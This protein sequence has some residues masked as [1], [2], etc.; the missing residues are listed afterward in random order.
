MTH[1]QFDQTGLNPCLAHVHIMVI[2][3]TVS[4]NIINVYLDLLEQNPCHAHIHIIVM[5]CN[6][7][8]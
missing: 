5:I 6:L 7:C 8:L 3:C 4:G 1:E 2:I